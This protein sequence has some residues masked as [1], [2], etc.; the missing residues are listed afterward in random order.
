MQDGSFRL[1]I[2]VW[3]AGNITGVILLKCVPYL[4]S[5]VTSLTHTEALYKYPL[6]Y[7]LLNFT[8]QRRPVKQKL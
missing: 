5:L 4:S 6:Y 2:N 1:W 7:T 3:V 8:R